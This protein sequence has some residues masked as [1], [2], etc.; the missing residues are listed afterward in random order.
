VTVKHGLAKLDMLNH[1]WLHSLM[2]MR[3][4]HYDICLMLLLSSTLLDEFVCLE[5]I[6]YR[7][8]C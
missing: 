1:D 4:I 2:K 5:V 3:Q 8:T 6:K 7:Y